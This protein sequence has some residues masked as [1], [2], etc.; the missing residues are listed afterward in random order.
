MKTETDIQMNQ[1]KIRNILFT[2]VKWLE[3]DD[4]DISA[5]DFHCA[6]KLI[7]FMLKRFP[8]IDEN[9][10]KRFIWENSSSINFRIIKPIY[11]PEVWIE[12]KSHL[13][14]T[15]KYLLDGSF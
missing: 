10:M 9:E 6:P 13:Q 1:T 5:I 2:S 7:E 12:I 4:W 14:R 8:H 3:L 11:Q 15:Q